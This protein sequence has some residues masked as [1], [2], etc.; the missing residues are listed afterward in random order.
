MK[1]KRP[2]AIIGFTFLVTCCLAIKMPKVKLILLLASF[3]ALIAVHI[4]TS[5]RYTQQ[6][7]LVFIVALM[8][9][10]YIYTYA[11]GYEKNINLIR[12]D[13]QVF[14]GIVVDNR[15]YEWSN[16]I[17]IKLFGKEFKNGTV[18]LY[19]SDDYEIGDV[20]K[21]TGF[22]K[23]LSLKENIE[24]NY[25]KNIIGSI[26][27]EDIRFLR[28]EKS[29][30]MK[31]KE[32]ITSKVEVLYNKNQAPIV[33]AMGWSEKSL[34]SQDINEL[35]M[36]AGIS[37]A[38][39]VSG[40]HISIIFLF[41]NLLMKFIPL[42][43][44][45]KNIIISVFLIMFMGI[46]GYSHSVI[47]AGVVAV[48]AIISINL[49]FE[50]DGLT[51]LGFIVLIT[52]IINPYAAS[53]VG[54]LLSYSACLG[55]LYA[56][57]LSKR[58]KLSRIKSN[59]LTA[60]MAV[61]FTMPIMAMSGMS[62]T[63]LSPIYNVLLLPIISAI[64]ILS[65]FTP[66][67]ACIGI[68]GQ[69]M[70][71]ELAFV[72]KNIINLLI[73]LLEVIHKYFEFSF[74]HLSDEKFQ[75]LI[76]SVLIVWCLC[77]LHIDNIKIIRIVSLTVAMMVF[78]CYNFINYNFAEVTAF[79][80]G[81][82]TSFIISVKGKQYLILSEEISLAKA[83]KMLSMYN[84]NKYDKIVVCSSKDIPYNIYNE[85]SK[86]IVNASGKRGLNDLEFDFKMQKD[87][88]NKGE[89][90]IITISENTIVFGH[91]KITTDFTEHRDFYFLG[92]DKPAVVNAENIFC[93]YPVRKW[94]YNIINDEDII[95]LYANLK[96]KINLNTGRYYIKKDV[97]NFGYYI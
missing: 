62:I 92:N 73:F 52:T 46:V 97:I 32:K 37:H 13:E 31:I 47:R 94:F 35:F 49:R 50:Q 90:Y 1:I 89:K 70:A 45:F 9:S 68:I 64:C 18:Y 93:Y 11:E 66:M 82:E 75:I 40:F 74:V 43:K 48:I 14:T 76:Y 39:V 12:Q 38:L 63:I 44:K 15:H 51:T 69:C 56:G 61:L 29:F 95:R 10:I 30:F 53:N 65:F 87:I 85:I 27:V 55:V 78:I 59:L 28:T 23:K 72:N 41:L 6:L 91:G 21:V 58:K 19:T 83:E 2:L 96:I 86:E 33:L 8:S 77:K 79:D 57:H 17:Y 25:S 24:Y 84:K 42:N 54:L 3:V 88:N 4:F 60:L 7:I 16:K 20:L 22:F 26:S 80:S 36:S 34:L 81:Y 71:V 67:L 5:K